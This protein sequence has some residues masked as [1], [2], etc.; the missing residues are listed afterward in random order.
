MII[1]Y[2]MFYYIKIYN[3]PFTQTPKLLMSFFNN[4]HEEEI[5]DKLICRIIKGPKKKLKKAFER[6][7]YAIKEAGK[8]GD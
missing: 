8:I 4:P 2:L 5:T 1:V 3:K 6:G 7:F